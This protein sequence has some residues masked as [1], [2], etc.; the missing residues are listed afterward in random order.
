MID[1]PD[2]A[3]QLDELELE[4][5]YEVIQD[6]PDGYRMVFNL[7]AIEGYAHKEIGQ[8]LGIS[9]ST[10]R[11]QYTRAKMLLRKRINEDHMEPNFYQD[12]S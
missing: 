5:L 12:V 3:D 8:K 10:S 6:L 1:N 4:Y 11:S 2:F 9:E 7:Y